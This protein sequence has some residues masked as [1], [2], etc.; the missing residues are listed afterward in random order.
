MAELLTDRDSVFN[1]YRQEMEA[2]NRNMQV[3]QLPDEVQERVRNFA[4]YQF[5]RSRMVRPP[6]RS[7]CQLCGWGRVVFTL[8]RSAVLVWC[9]CSAHAV[10]NAHAHRRKCVATLT[11]FCIA[12]APDSRRLAMRVPMM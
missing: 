4:A 10:L 5:Q 8:T 12:C 7:L 11:N 6:A 2:V 9:P 1:K 3:L